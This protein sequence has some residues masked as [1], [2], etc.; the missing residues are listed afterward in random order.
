MKRGQNPQISGYA[1]YSQEKNK[2]TGVAKNSL[3]KLTETLPTFN[4]W[5]LDGPLPDSIQS[6]SITFGGL[7][8]MKTLYAAIACLF[9]LTLPL[10]VQAKTVCGQKTHTKYGETRIFA[11]SYIATCRADGSCAAV[12]YQMNAGTKKADA[13]LGWDHRMSISRASPAAPWEITLTAVTVVPD[14]SEGIDMKIDRDGGNKVPYEFLRAGS[15]V[16]EL[17]IDTKLTDIF[18]AKFKPGNKVRWDYS[19]KKDGAPSTTLFSLI[20]LTKA[21]KWIDCAQTKT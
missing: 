6:H 2:Y 11:K 9:S 1:R 3:P 20:G 21:M 19:V 14:I 10:A 17:R 12:T 13:P 7:T 5:P 4:G 15:A 8:K 16:N 18:L